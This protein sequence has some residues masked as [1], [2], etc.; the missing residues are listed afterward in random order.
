[1]T[2]QK[3]SVVLGSLFVMASICYGA[4]KHYSPSLI[5]FVVEQSLLQ[6]SPSGIDSNSL[7]ERFQAVI[8]AAPDKS[9]KMERLLRISEYLEKVQLLSSD[10]LNQLLAIEKPEKPR[11]LRESIGFPEDAVNKAGEHPAL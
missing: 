2:I 1:M 10:E 8:S 4:A 11:V 3:R 6:K 7:R 9:S 5:Y